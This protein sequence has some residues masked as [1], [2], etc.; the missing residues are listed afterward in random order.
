MKQQISTATKDYLSLDHFEVTSISDTNI[1]IR[2]FTGR[3]YRQ[4]L[5][6]VKYTQ[7]LLSDDESS[8]MFLKHLSS[9]Y[10]SS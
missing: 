3:F 1:R 5:E 4:D 9:C 8:K 2:P 6:F 10:H 7:E